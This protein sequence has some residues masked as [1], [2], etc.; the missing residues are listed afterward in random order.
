MKFRKKPVVIEAIEFNGKESYEKMCVTWQEFRERTNY[1]QWS[2]N[3]YINTLRGQTIAC[4]NDWIIKGAKGEFY[5]CS[6]GIFE[7][8]YEKVE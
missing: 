8:T 1:Q 2:Q 3:I 7:A 5:P 4:G 6:P